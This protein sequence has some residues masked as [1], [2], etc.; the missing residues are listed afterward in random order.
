[1]II[2]ENHFVDIDASGG[3]HVGDDRPI[4][5]IY[6]G[7]FRLG[8]DKWPVHGLSYARGKCIS[9]STS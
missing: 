3:A 8:L 2:S 5:L 4:L 6:K 9:R 1:M 7:S